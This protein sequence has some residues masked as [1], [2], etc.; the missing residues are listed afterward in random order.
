MLFLVIAVNYISNTKIQYSDQL[1]KLQRILLDIFIELK[2]RGVYWQ[3]SL[4]VRMWD[5][6]FRTGPSKC[7]RKCRVSLAVE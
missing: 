2:L 7:N 1:I 3:C 4:T 5:L 6:I